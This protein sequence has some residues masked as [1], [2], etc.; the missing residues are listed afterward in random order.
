MD[1]Q[2]GDEDTASAAKRCSQARATT[3]LEKKGTN[4]SRLLWDLYR[5]ASSSGVGPAIGAYDPGRIGLFF[6]KEH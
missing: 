5:H 6:R 3:N 2:H 1:Q 4:W